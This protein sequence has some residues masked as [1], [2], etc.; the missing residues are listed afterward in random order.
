VVAL[1][2]QTR[3]KQTFEV[4]P[5][6]DGI[7]WHE[8]NEVVVGEP[9]EFVVEFDGIVH[10]HSLEHGKSLEAS[11]KDAFERRAGYLSTSVVPALDNF[12]VELLNF[13]QAEKDV[14]R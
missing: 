11:V 13:T 12:P 1:C 4:I 8:W 3:Y 5:Q 2:P 10:I 6:T 14:L 9:L 7:E